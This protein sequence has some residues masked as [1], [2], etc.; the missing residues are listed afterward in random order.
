[1]IYSAG[2]LI[3]LIM[4]QPLP[5]KARHRSARNRPR[6]NLTWAFSRDSYRTWQ[7]LRPLR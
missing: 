4:R 7:L 6:C 2:T 3:V 5:W 1:M